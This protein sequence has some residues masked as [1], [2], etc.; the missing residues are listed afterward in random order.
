MNKV[1]LLL[2]ALVFSSF[3]IGSYANTDV[4]QEQIDVITAECNQEA[5]DATDP[6]VYKENCIEDRLEVLKEQSGQN[7]KDES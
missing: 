5:N 4:S 2:T 6:A 1:T 3:S 7:Q